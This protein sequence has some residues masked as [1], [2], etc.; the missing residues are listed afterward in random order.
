MVS[1]IYPARLLGLGHRGMAVMTSKG[2][3]HSFPELFALLYVRQGGFSNFRGTITPR[4]PNK[5]VKARFSREEAAQSMT[6]LEYGKGSTH[7]SD[8]RN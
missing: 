8:G 7:L 2:Y 5:G 4:E 1:E 3:H 6:V